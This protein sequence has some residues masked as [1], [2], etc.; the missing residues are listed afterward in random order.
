VVEV[1]VVFEPPN[2]RIGFNVCVSVTVTA[3]CAVNDA[4]TERLEP[5][6]VLLLYVTK[7]LA[8]GGA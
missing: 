1:V 2:P 3:V 6:I 7:L 8:P 4:V 5:N